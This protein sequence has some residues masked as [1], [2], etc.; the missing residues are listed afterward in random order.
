V[1]GA[2]LLVV[3][4]EYTRK[5]Y[6]DYG[7]RMGNMPRIEVVPYPIHP[8]IGEKLDA[9]QLAQKT[10]QLDPDSAETI[11]VS[12]PISGAAVGTAH[13]SALMDHLR[14]R[15]NRF[16]FHV[17]CKD[18][19]FTADFL[20][21]LAGKP[22]IDVRAGKQDR[23]VVDRYDVLLETQ[24]LALEVTKPSEQTFKCLAPTS[25]R[26]GVILLFTEPVGVQEF[27]NMNFLRR[28]SLVPSPET[29]V[30]LWA[31]AADAAHMDTALRSRLLEVAGLWRGV[32]IPG[33]A[34]QAAGF[35]WWMQTSGFFYR[36]MQGNLY[37][38]VEDEEGRVLGPNGV[39]QFWDLATSL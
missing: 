25:A 33:D 39:E 13:F 2:D 14:E 24:T 31:M 38:T 8:R 10:R 34:Q 23:E 21:G 5:K 35:I 4:S 37:R 9:A 32:R 6:V 16:L 20:A 29:N 12:I 19:P 11:H 27:D 18:A 1:D 26:G 7:E 17:V 28:S 3:P 30:Q 22:W 36:M 15:S